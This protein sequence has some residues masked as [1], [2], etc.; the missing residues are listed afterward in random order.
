MGDTFDLLI[1]GGV[2]ATPGGLVETDVAVRGGRIA[3]IGDLGAASAAEEIDARNLHVLPGVIDTQ[4]HLREPGLEHKEDIATGTAAAILGGVTAVFDMPNTR[5]STLTAADLA[6]KLSRA[7]GRAW[8]D[9]AFFV[10]AAVE[11]VDRLAELERLPGCAGVKVFMGSS[12]GTLLVKDEEVLA[13]ILAGGFRRVAVHAEDEERLVE[14]RALVGPGATAHMH[15]VWRDEVAAVQATERMLGLAGGARRRVHILHVSTAEEMG[16]LSGFRD[17]AT[18]EVT[19]QHLTLAAPECYDAL[20][21]YAQM[22]PPIRDA[23][24]RDALWKAVREGVVD[25]IGSDHA[26][27]TREEKDRPY[28]ESPSGM[29]GVQT[30][31]PIMLDHVHAGRLTLERLVDLTSAGPAR[32]YG[33]AAKGRLA[34]GYDADLTLVDLGARRRISNQAMASRAG[35][36]PFDG[37]EVQGWPAATVVRGHVVMRDDEII[38]KPRGQPVRFVECL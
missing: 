31:L 14:R 18:V 33:I 30:L 20:G 9:I 2:C 5:P 8:C 27:H 17:I 19:P 1:R 35:W 36:T 28:P 29:P 12:T 34:V 3:A 23:R 25:V 4:V 10:G 16:L 38:D 15:P 11:N 22:N 7:S 37:R 21:A 32:V 26:P 13:Q 24:H 6:D